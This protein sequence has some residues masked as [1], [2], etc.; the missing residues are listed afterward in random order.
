MQMLSVSEVQLIAKHRLAKIAGKA[1]QRPLASISPAVSD[2]Y[3][4]VLG[5]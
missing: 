4:K 5:Y 3:L 1:N 2:V